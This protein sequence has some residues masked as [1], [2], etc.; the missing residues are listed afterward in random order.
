[1]S[2]FPRSADLL[3][4]DVL[5]EFTGRPL[6]VL[7]P[8]FDDACFALGGFLQALSLQPERAVLVDVFTEGDHVARRDKHQPSPG[9]R[10]V[11]RL[12]SA[13]DRAFADTIGLSRL[14]LSAE[15]PSLRGRGIKQL[16]FIE[17]DVA[18]IA[19]PLTDAFTRLADRFADMRALLFVPLGMSWHCN[20]R[21]VHRYIRRNDAWLRLHFDIFYYEDMPYASRLRF[22]WRELKRLEAFLAGAV[23][24]HRAIGWCEKRQL[25]QYYPS[26]FARNPKWRKFRPAALWPLPIH[27][28][29][30]RC[31]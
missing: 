20:H 5:A 30:W 21:A 24:Y 10:D 26:Q 16:D 13:E 3:R 2:L 28:A 8:H 4:A 15:E 31:P 27:E 25:L 12:R 19:Q 7:A 18:Q 14:E 29:F 22:R 17:E 6:V 1:M 11:V 23:R 9:R